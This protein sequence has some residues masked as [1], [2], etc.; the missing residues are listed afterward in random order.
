MAGLD[1]VYTTSVSHLH[2]RVLIIKTNTLLTGSKTGNQT[3]FERPV[4]LTLRTHGASMIIYCSVAVTKGCGETLA[5]L[6]Q[7]GKK[8]DAVLIVLYIFVMC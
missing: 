5:L 6:L 2:L 4:G 1:K 7:E 3:E 8:V